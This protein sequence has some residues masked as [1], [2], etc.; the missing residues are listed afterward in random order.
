M[1]IEFI[2]NMTAT[3]MNCDNLQFEPVFADKFSFKIHFQTCFDQKMYH[4]LFRSEMYHLWT[5]ATVTMVSFG[6]SV[7]Q[8]DHRGQ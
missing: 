3:I 7:G 1:I 2:V 8:L 6:V 4:Q 5:S